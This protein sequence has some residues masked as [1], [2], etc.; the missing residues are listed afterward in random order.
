MTMDVSDTTSTAPRKA[1]RWPWVLAGLAALMAAFSTQV[2]LFVIQPIGALPEGRT[3]LVWRS[4]DM[5]LI[6]SADSIC[7]RRTGKVSLLCRG[8]ATI[9]FVDP[10]DVLLRMPYSETL[11]LI[12]TDGKHFD[13]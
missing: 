2:S 4:S 1:K 10:D 3:L 12:S 5:R 6:D 8:M 7:L 13:R 9:R 11:Y